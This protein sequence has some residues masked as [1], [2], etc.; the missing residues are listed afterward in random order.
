MK[1]SNTF[2]AIDYGTRKSGLAYS[3]E[4]FAFAYETVPTRELLPTLQHLI[5][6]KSAQGIII[7]MPYNIDGTISTHGRRVQSYVD[8][9]RKH[10]SLPILYRDER[11][12]TTEA[13]FWLSEM[14]ENADIDAESARLILESYLESQE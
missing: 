7:G 5:A 13:T 12:T 3:V 9:L 14:G 6:K 8:I 2:I 11:L 4:W 1:L 10:I